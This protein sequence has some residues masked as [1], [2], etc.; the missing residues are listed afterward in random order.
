MEFE[1]D[2]AKAEANERKHSVTFHEGAAIF[3]DQM[4]ITF[5]DPDHS[6][7][8]ER[9]LTFGQSNFSRFLVVSHTERDGKTRIIHVRMMTRRERIVYEEG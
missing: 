7:R 5:A 4:A 1:W 9:F 8:E 2:P 6:E 3:G